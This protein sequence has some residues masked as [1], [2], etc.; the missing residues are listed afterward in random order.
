VV[1]AVPIS[2]T[3]QEMLLQA[4]ANSPLVER[5]KDVVQGSELAASLARK[6]Y[7]P[8]YTLSGGYFNQGGLP[9][10]WKGAG[11]FQTAGVFL[12]Q[13]ACRGDRQEASAS[14]APPRVCGDAVEV[15]AEIREQY[16][17]AEA[18]LKLVNLYEED[19]DSG[20]AA[21]V[22]IR[23]GKLPSRARRFHRAVYQFHQRGG[24]YN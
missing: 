5:G 11:G 20:G 2:A 16:S 21:G 3:L 19:G 24:L 18:S 13:A 4:R 15:E 1:T 10:L 9:P 6:D 12:A 23:A 8:D 17:T 14:Q 7:A 22:R